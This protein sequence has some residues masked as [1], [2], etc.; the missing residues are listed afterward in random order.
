MLRSKKSWTL[1]DGVEP[2]PPLAAPEG[3]E[4]QHWEQAM[5]YRHIG[6]GRASH[7]DAWTVYFWSA[8]LP[9][10]TKAQAPA[11]LLE[12]GVFNGGTAALA[13]PHVRPAEIMHLVDIRKSRFLKPVLAQAPGDV[14][15]RVRFHKAR[16]D[17]P[18]LRSLE[19]K[20]FRWIHIDAGHEKDDV[21]GDLDR[22]APCL[23]DDGLL[24]LDDFFQPAWPQVT[25]ATYAF[26]AS[27]GDG[28]QPV[29]I[30]FNKLYV[31]RPAFVPRAREMIQTCTEALG[32]L[33]RLNVADT[34]MADRQ[35]MALSGSLSAKYHPW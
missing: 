9:H 14:A 1:P 35:V 20:R 18:S 11:D 34:A 15:R 28:F 27:Q 33:G 24:V 5:H 8:L 3:W 32:K 17:S 6:I 13:Y 29:C 16:T 23:A 12:L 26:L 25:E 21:A 4:D 2:L 22:F 19:R 31:A 10:L 7:I 30:A